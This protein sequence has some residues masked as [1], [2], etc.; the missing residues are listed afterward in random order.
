M[1]R[2]DCPDMKAVDR[3]FQRERCE[4]PRAAHQEDQQG[5]A[6]VQRAGGDYQPA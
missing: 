3:L 2:V 4:R 1:M 6:K 5:R